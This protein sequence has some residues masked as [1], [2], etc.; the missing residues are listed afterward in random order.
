MALWQMEQAK[1]EALGI[2]GRRAVQEFVLHPEH[3]PFCQLGRTAFQDDAELVAAETGENVR[4]AEMPLYQFDVMAEIP[5]ALL[6]AE[7]VVDVFQ[8]VEVT[9]TEDQLRVSFQQV[10]RVLFKIIPVTDL[11]QRVKMRFQLQRVGVILFLL[12]LLSQH[13]LALLEL[14]GHGVERFRELAQIGDVLGIITLRD[15]LCLPCQMVQVGVDVFQVLAQ[16]IATGRVAVGE[17]AGGKSRRIGFHL[18]NGLVEVLQTHPELLVGLVQRAD[19][20]RL[21]F[22]VVEDAAEIFK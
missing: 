19:V 2:L 10:I 18:L 22:G 5:V 15:L 9:V 4:R 11:G 12:S 21:C 16:G 17:V 14:S 8:M 1:A 6:V 3:L 20:Q 13:G 7:V